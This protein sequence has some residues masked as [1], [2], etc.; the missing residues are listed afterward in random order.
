MN[1]GRLRS[2]RSN[3]GGGTVTEM[4]RSRGGRLAFRFLLGGRLGNCRERGALPL[5]FGQAHL[6][7]VASFDEAELPAF[8][9][10][11]GHEGRPTGAAAEHDGEDGSKGRPGSGRVGALPW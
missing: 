10:V 11:G 6:V 5:H 7:V 9:I 3:K 1:S 8:G 4:P 2:K